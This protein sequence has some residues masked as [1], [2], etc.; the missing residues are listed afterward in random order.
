MAAKLIPRRG[1]RQERESQLFLRSVT[2]I[3][4]WEEVS[5]A[6]QKRQGGIYSYLFFPC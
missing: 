6:Q 3:N 1:E 4:P 5:I 2:A